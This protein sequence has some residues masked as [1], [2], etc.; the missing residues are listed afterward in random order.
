MAG[1][2]EPSFMARHLLYYLIGK[3]DALVVVPPV[4]AELRVAV[5]IGEAVQ[6]QPVGV[7]ARVVAHV[8]DVLAI[9]LYGPLHLG[10]FIDVDVIFQL[11]I[12][13]RDATACASLVAPETARSK[14]VGRL[15]G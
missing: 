8:D 12:G 13:S 9:G 11:R 14:L 4:V 6:L 10:K 7:V 1:A 2:M 15:Q 5:G 3:A